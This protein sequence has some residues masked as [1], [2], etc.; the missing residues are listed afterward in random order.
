MSEWTPEPS[1]RDT[2][3][4]RVH[5]GGPCRDDYPN[6]RTYDQGGGHTVLTLQGPAM[7]A[8]KAAEARYGK[9][10]GRPAEQR[11]IRVLPGTNRTCATQARLYK[12]DPDRYAKPE[13]T[14]HTRGL[15]IDVDQSQPN[16][17]IIHH[18]L[19]AE[20]WTQ[21]R[22]REEPWHYSYGYTI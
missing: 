4:G 8:F 7:R 22:P 14:G 1:H 6:M 9:R 20:G 18:C 13:V 5:Y 19:T 16:L 21:T 11:D 15:A 12:E 17:S 3:Y 2:P 10:T